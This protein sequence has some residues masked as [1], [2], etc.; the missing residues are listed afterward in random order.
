MND[1]MIDIETMGTRSTSMIVQIGACY[2]DRKTGEIGKKFKVNVTYKNDSDFTIDH[3]TID[4]WLG[5]DD[6]ARQSIVGD[7]VVINR[8]VELLAEF[9]KEAQFIWSHATFDIPIILHAFDV[10]KTTFPIHY[11]KMRDI[12]T[13]IDIKNSNQRSSIARSGTHHDALDDCIFQVQ[14]CVEALNK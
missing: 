5:R 2:F 3:S 1:V 10:C 12:R 6:K 9:L 4:W 13:L 11:T 7:A 8:A 14:Y